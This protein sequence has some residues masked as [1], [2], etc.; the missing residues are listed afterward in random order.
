MSHELTST[1]HAV[2][3]RNRPAWHGL[4]TVIP[5]TMS[6]SEAQR[7]A[8]LDW[9]VDTE[10]AFVSTPGGFVEAP[11]AMLTVRSD[12]V[13]ADRVLGIVGNRYTPIQ[14]TEL[15]EFMDVLAG[16]GGAKIDT[17]GSLKG[18]RMVWALAM[19]PNAMKI[20]SD[21]VNRYLLVSTS[22]D[23]SSSMEAIVTPVRVVCW[24]TLSAAIGAS[25]TA[26]RRAPRQRI[27]IRHTANA[28]D[29]IAHA[30]RVLGDA[31]ESFERCR[32]VF[33]SWA[34]KKVS[35]RYVSA[36]LRA[37]FPDP[38]GSASSARAASTRNDVME[39]YRYRQIGADMPELR[40]T[41][42]GLFNGLTQYIDRERSTRAGNRS[43]GEARL[44]STWYGSGAS[45]R[46]R[47]A[48]LLEETLDSYSDYDG[49]SPLDLIHDPQRT[50]G[51]ALLDSLLN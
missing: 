44:E 7:Y 48:T 43:T 32:E 5:G 25:P 10:P 37:M 2:Y 39:L 29:R 47:G 23:G 14:N 42:W 24:N 6:S 16:E 4:G 33:S 30:K 45:L 12:L 46:Q 38:A 40:G 3:G 50:T 35:Q 15:F 27:T 34:T 22:H 19:L 36:F 28:R 49:A 20:G 17:A 11:G 9:R 8:R 51:E 1:D 41:A 21:R 18:G 26:G 31:S 13:G